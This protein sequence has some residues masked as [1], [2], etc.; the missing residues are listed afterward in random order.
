[1][2]LLHQCNSSDGTYSPTESFYKMN[3]AGSGVQTRLAGNILG[4]K[5]ISNNRSTSALVEDRFLT[6]NQLVNREKI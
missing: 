3:W 6:L 5:Y 1:M 2:S 4:G